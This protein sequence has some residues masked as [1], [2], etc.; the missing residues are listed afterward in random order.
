MLIKCTNLYYFRV[1]SSIGGIET[2]FYQLAKKYKDTD[3]VVVYNSADIKQLERLKKYVKCIKYTNQTFKCERAFFNF[4]TDIID[5]VE[6]K[7][8]V[9]VIHGDYE[10]MVKQN[11]LSYVPDHS[12]ITR[13][14]GVSERACR[15]YTAM[16]GKPCELCYN[17]FELDTSE[18]KPL[19]LISATRLTKEKGKDRMVQLANA[20]DKNNIPYIWLVFTND[21]NAIDNP[22]IIYMK[23]RLDVVNFIQKA[24]YLVQLS[25]NEGYCYTIVEAESLG[26]PSIIT[27]CPVFEELGLKD[28]ENCYVLNF[29]MSNV[30]E[31]VDK[32]KKSKLNFKYT[33]K[34]DR[35]NE[36]LVPSKSTYQEELNTLYEVEALD[37]YEKDFRSDAQLNKI[38]KAGERWCVDKERLDILLGNNKYNKAYV[39]LIN[40]LKKDE[41]KEVI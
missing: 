4:N 36:L 1:I 23:P 34:E 15:G 37:T 19:L 30:Q 3:L 20:L 41:A 7:D 18:N 31:V 22:N 17:P 39:K 16:T 29:D 38:P 27:P 9:L 14:V 21:K 12:K 13:Y 6:A 26:V 25:N 24:D 32:L 40:T 8:Y 2:F 33:P 28:N 35:W 5:K 10:T 11:Q